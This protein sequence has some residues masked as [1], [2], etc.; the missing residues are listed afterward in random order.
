M[1]LGIPGRI[2]RFG[3]DCSAEVDFGGINRGVQLD[4]LKDVKVG[5]YV[6]VHAGFAIQKLSKKDAL[7]TL[8]IIR[9]A[10][11]SA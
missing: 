3:R 2:I 4:L 6:I 10:G 9:E 5:D 7:E 8:K 11:I 1:C